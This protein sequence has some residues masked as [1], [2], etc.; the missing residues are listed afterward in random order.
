[1]QGGLNIANELELDIEWDD[2]VKQYV[3]TGIVDG[4]SYSIWLE[5]E[6]SLEAKMAVVRNRELAGVACWSLGMELDSVWDI[7]TE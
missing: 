7:I 5:E 1:M 3:A 2:E 6:K 4:V